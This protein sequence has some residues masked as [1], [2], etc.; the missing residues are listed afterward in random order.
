[1]QNRVHG[2]IRNRGFIPF[3][4]PHNRGAFGFCN[5]IDKLLLFTISGARGVNDNILRK[6]RGFAEQVENGHSVVGMCFGEGVSGNPYFTEIGNSGEPSNFG[7]V[8]EVIVS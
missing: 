3:E 5:T 4:S 2:F 1:V 7:W 8:R 6:S